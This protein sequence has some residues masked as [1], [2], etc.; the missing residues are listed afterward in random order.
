[1]SKV[2]WK[3]LSTQCAPEAQGRLLLHR[4]C[5]HQSRRKEP[6]GLRT[7]AI[8]QNPTDGG[9]RMDHRAKAVMIR[10]G[11]YKSV[12]DRGQEVHPQVLEKRKLARRQRQSVRMSAL[13]NKGRRVNLVRPPRQKG[14]KPKIN[15]GR[16][17]QHLTKPKEFS[18]I[19]YTLCNFRIR[20]K[21]KDQETYAMM[22]RLSQLL[23]NVVFTTD[24][25]Y[26]GTLEYLDK[27]PGYVRIG[28]KPDFTATALLLK[29]VLLC[30][31]NAPVSRLCMVINNQW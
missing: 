9:P 28:R 14:A 22:C 27:V 7:K 19:H 25:V 12:S 17:F 2:G 6:S 31:S 1:M 3:P 23:V 16:G 10:P 26:G 13:G 21:R 15:F 4:S 8:R 5:P 11:K 20:R 24:Y 18:F 29:Q 30:R